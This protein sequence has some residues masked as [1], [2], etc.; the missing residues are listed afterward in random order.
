MPEFLQI[1]A[2]YFLGWWRELNS[3]LSSFPEVREQM[4]DD[5]AADRAEMLDL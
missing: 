3:L 4:R 1:G 5:I 2:D